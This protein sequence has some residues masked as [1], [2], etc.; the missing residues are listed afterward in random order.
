MSKKDRRSIKTRSAM[1]KN[2]QWIHNLRQEVDFKV[3]RPY[4]AEAILSDNVFKLKLHVH[5][6]LHATFNLDKLNSYVGNPD[7]F[8]GRQLP[9]TSRVFFLDDKG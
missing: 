1:I 5:M 7:Q 6:K 9:K 8:E 3:D 2:G 4:K